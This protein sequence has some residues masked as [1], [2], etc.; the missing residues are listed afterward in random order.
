[1]FVMRLVC[2]SGEFVGLSDMI[3]KMWREDLCGPVPDGSSEPVQ[4]KAERI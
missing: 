1:M 2:E 4:D 3:F